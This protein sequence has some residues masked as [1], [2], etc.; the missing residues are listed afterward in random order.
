MDGS[1]SFATSRVAQDRENIENT[2][3][4][5]SIFMPMKTQYHIIQHFIFT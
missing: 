2:H 1:I 5:D 3:I 4:S